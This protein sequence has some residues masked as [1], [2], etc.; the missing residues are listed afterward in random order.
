VLAHVPIDRPRVVPSQVTQ[1]PPDRLP[2]EVFAVAEVDLDAVAQERHV[3]LVLGV[4][5]PL[6]LAA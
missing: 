1:G 6:D 3:G 5:V 4:A 2:H